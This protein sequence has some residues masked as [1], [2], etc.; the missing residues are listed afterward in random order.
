MLKRY[1][2]FA[3]S[4]GMGN[5]LGGIADLKNAFH[6]REEAEK[7][8]SEMEK[9]DDWFDNTDVIDLYDTILFDKGAAQ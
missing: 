9:R 4:Q 6:T 1:A 8:V 7:W 2:V 3:Y 5:E